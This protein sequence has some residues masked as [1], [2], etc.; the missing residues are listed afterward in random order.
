MTQ[1]LSDG[2]PGAGGLAEVA[3]S[4]RRRL[5]NGAKVQAGQ[6]SQDREALLAKAEP[7]RLA[8]SPAPANPA[9]GFGWA[10]GRLSFDE[11]LLQWPCEIELEPEPDD[12]AFIDEAHR[13][14]LLRTAREAERDQYL[15]LL[16]DGVVTRT[17]VIEDLLA[18]AELRSLERRLR[19]IYEG[20]VITAPGEL[21]TAKMPAVTWPG[22][23]GG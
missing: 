12:A 14:I 17:W 8:P 4:A 6:G 10:R 15:R 19:V 11:F 1:L 9:G 20:R 2:D 22:R 21:G 7:L 23:S 16:R 13:A 18:S 3:R 5:R